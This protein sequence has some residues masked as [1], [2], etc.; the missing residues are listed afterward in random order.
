[1]KSL[2]LVCDCG[3]RK[4]FREVFVKSRPKLRPDAKENRV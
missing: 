1:M 2:T 3:A 4:T